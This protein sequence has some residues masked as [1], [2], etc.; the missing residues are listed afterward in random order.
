M[1]CSSLFLL[2][3]CQKNQK[4]KRKLIIFHLYFSYNFIYIITQVLFLD[5]E[6]YKRHPS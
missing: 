2:K 3:F 1:M 6:D 5:V 4:D